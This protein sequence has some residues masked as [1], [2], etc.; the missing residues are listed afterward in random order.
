[1]AYDEWGKKRKNRGTYDKTRWEMPALE[2]GKI[3][4]SIVETGFFAEPHEWKYA[5]FRR[6]SPQ[7][8]K[9]KGC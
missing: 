6:E 4:S 8:I 5:V 3:F 9:R 7:T 2:V 1:V